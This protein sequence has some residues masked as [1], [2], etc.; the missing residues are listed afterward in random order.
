MLD[1]VG[2]SSGYVS[3]E[4]IKIL[5]LNY[6]FGQYSNNTVFLCRQYFESW[7]GGRCLE[8]GQT[9]TYTCQCPIKRY[10]HAYI[11]TNKTQHKHTNNIQQISNKNTKVS[12]QPH[13]IYWMQPVQ[14]THNIL[15][16]CSTRILCCRQV[17]V[18][19]LLSLLVEA[20]IFI[21]PRFKTTDGRGYE[22]SGFWNLR[23]YVYTSLKQ[24]QPTQLS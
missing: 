2:V 13:C 24:N 1:Q 9:I 8:Q 15:H 20:E 21:P 7:E 19:C 3:C 16:L 14:T 6:V 5:T 12:P 22:L 17:Q 18:F 10:Q 4:T 23:H 11:R